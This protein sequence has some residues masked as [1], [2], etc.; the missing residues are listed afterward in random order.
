MKAEE[1]KNI[2]EEFILNYEKYGSNMHLYDIYADFKRA[3]SDTKK[4]SRFAPILSKI[5]KIKNVRLVDTMKENEIYLFQEV[6]Y[7]TNEVVF[8][9]VVSAWNAK[10]EFSQ[11]DILQVIYGDKYK[12]Y[13]KENI[14]DTDKT[15]IVY[16]EDSSYINEIKLYT[17]SKEELNL[18]KEKENK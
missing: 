2:A 7:R 16:K 5:L 6:D 1:L 11:F 15:I 4:V 8:Q 18:L 14:D 13:L 10:E 17:Y 12:N 3:L 9:M